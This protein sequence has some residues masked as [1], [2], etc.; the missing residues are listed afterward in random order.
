MTRKSL[1]WGCAFIT[2]G[3][4]LLLYKFDLIQTELKV[5]LNLWPVFFI[6]AGL[7]LLKI[8]DIIRKAVAGVAGI[9]LGLIVAGVLFSGWHIARFNIIDNFD[10][11]SEYSM[12]FV[13]DTARID[14]DTNIR[15]VDLKLNTAAG[16]FIVSDSGTSLADIIADS[17][18]T[19]AFRRYD[20]SGDVA[21]L[22]LSI[23][24][25]SMI[26]HDN[27]GGFPPSRILLNNAPVWN[28]SANTGAADFQADLSRLRVES[29][30][31]KGGATSVSVR[32]G[33]LVDR[34]DVRIKTGASSVKLY[35][36]KS[37]GCTIKAKTGLSDLTADMF[38]KVGKNLYKSSNYDSTSK[39]ID[40]E[41]KGG[42]S[43]FVIDRY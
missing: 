5:F 16:S 31:L 30:S 1:F 14:L 8:N 24:N 25:R 38:E 7:S 2:L 15:A 17:R 26:F 28:I 10:E 42:V 22:K 34:A 20:A 23:N 4:S 12:V 37:V 9:L 32:F 40:I 36:P 33:D 13:G 6:L 41:V 11:D 43:S 29:F 39:R 19:K 3:L 21:N 35:V 27:D 18:E